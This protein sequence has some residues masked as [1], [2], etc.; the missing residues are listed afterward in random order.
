MVIDI[1]L[2]VSLI[3]IMFS[4]GLGLTIKDFKNIMNDPIVFFVGLINQM[5]IL[6]LI[7]F[8]III[9]FNLS[10]ELAVGMIILSC[11]PG[12]VTSNII[13][14]LAKGDTALSISYTAVVS[15]VS[16]FTLPLIVGYSIS[17]FNLFDENI[18]S[19]SILKL[20]MTMFIITTI[21]VLFGLYINVKHT[22]ISKSFYPIANIISTFLFIIIIIGALASEWNTFINNLEFLGPSIITLIFTM[23]MIG[24]NTPKLFGISKKQ[25]ITIAIESGI[26]N[27]TIGITIGN[28]ILNQSQGISVLSLPSGVYSILMY[29]VCLPIIYF[30][31]KKK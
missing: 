30:F 5:I 27:G 21:P 31:I 22:T 7:A 26:Q 24:Y 10:S 4:L 18:V 6:P 20:G 13:T 16:V 8:L 3:F 15:V 2:P 14:K 1:I 25:S 28:I 29:A 19:F 9:F 17:H 11:C 12:G 23:M